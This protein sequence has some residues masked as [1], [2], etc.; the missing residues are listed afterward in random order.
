MSNCII[1]VGL[2]GSG[3][4]S[5]AEE[6]AK[7]YHA[8]IISSDKLREEMFGDVADQ[9]HND[10]IFKEFH[11]RIALY[12]QHHQSVIVDATNVTMKSRRQIINIAQTYK[13]KVIVYVCTKPI[14]ACLAD[15][16]KREHPVPD[17]VIYKQ[18]GKFQIP[19]REE[20]IDEIY[21]ND[22]DMY[23]LND[24][25]I[26]EFN[27]YLH[28]FDIFNQQ[29][30]HHVLTLGQHC[31]NTYLHLP[32]S[33]NDILVHAALLHDI[34]KLFT[35]TIDEDGEA[36][37]YGHPNVG[38]YFLLSHLDR[39]EKLFGYEYD[40]YFWEQVAFYINYHMLP[41]DWKSNVTHMRYKHTFG[42]RKYN[43]LITLHTADCIGSGNE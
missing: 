12:L 16:K 38:S 5:K 33:T 20:G 22:Y 31:K 3:K 41:F 19:F 24:V 21:Y 28:E 2:S 35:Q 6:L 9:L 7:M 37:Y 42:T 23:S 1:M 27:K 10:E 34:G 4:F 11:H 17:Y 36:H 30:K 32:V 29:N 26:A 39:F 40:G 13:S 18:R 15:N 14:G 8:N 43:N 25:D